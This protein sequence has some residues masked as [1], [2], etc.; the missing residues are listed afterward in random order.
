MIKDVII[1]INNSIDMKQKLLTAS[2]V[3]LAFFQSC[4]DD[5]K[6]STPSLSGKFSMVSHEYYGCADAARNKTVQCPS[7]V[8]CREL[9]FLPD[10]KLSLYYPDVPRHDGTYQVVQNQLVLRDDYYNNGFTVIYTISVSGN[11]MTL[12]EEDVARECMEK[13]IYN[14]L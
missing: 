4:K 10:G 13:E 8:F 3:A 12:T 11:T 14:K 6:D 9:E 7:T 2:L 5:D 1:I